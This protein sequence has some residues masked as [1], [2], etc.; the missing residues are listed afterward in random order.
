MILEA[1]SNVLLE[2]VV[3]AAAERLQKRL[4]VDA[5]DQSFTTTQEDH[6]AIRDHLTWLN[7]WA[8]EISFR[9]LAKSKALNDS[10]VDLDLHLGIGRMQADREG[11]LQ[12]RVSDLPSRSGHHVLLGDPGAGK[13]TSLKQIASKELEGTATDSTAPIPVLIRLRQLRETATLTSAIRAILGIHIEFGRMHKS[14]QRAIDQRI[15]AQA[16]ERIGCVLLVDGLDEIHPEARM[17]AIDD[18]QFLTLRLVESRVL[19]TCRTGDY[20]YN[21]EGAQVVTL[22]PLTPGQIRQ[23]T[24]R[25]LGAEQ[26]P[27]LLDKIGQN[28]YAGAEVRPLTLAHL[29]A[30]YERY[31]TVPDKPKTVYR[32]IVRLLL[33]EWDLQR[34]VQRHTRY[35]GFEL[36]RKEEF[37]EAIAYQLT[38]RFRSFSFSHAQLEEAYVTIYKSFELPRLQAEGVVREIESHTGLLIESAYDRYEFAH[39]SIQE[40]LTASYIAKLPTVPFDDI[41]FMPHELALAT[42][43]S[44]DATTYCATVIRA[45]VAAKREN[46]AGFTEP[47]ISRLLL[48]R[49]VFVANPSFGALLLT[50]HANT[51]PAKHDTPYD[52]EGGWNSAL[53]ALLHQPSVKKS[54]R[55]ALHNAVAVWEDS[56]SYL[57]RV[58]SHLPEIDI[59]QS[60]EVDASLDLLIDRRLI[61]ALNFTLKPASGL[62]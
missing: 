60:A 17:N 16:L 48:E 57:I 2:K 54:V 39:K 15:T 20:R 24:V 4:K 19:L 43:L 14:L 44:S 21:L 9:E 18:L 49:V 1:L 55:A 47:F 46:L 35:S 5:E 8:G 28:P 52:R 58:P 13:T 34:G 51:Y 31:G 26:A 22:E 11:G 37:L 50:L 56:N 29:C 62:D 59:Y 10:F 40:Y 45:I 41:E 33:E 53:F 12:L 3:G 30:I 23:F 42:A 32:R 36:D 27:N 61:Q 7:R 6:S 25:W 38:Y